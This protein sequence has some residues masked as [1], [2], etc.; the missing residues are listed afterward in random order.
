MKKLVNIIRFSGTVECVTGLAIKG[1]GNDLGIGGADSEVIRNP[2]T[3]EPYLPGSS[4]K[5]R[6]RSQLERKYGTRDKY[7]GPDQRGLPCQ[8]GRADCKICTVFGAHFNPGAASAPTRIIVRDAC[9]TD[10]FRSQ[11]Q[12]LPTE[13][14]SY[15]ELKGENIINRKTGTAE[16]PRF[17]ERVPAGATFDFEILLQILEGDDENQLRSFVEEGLHLVE[18][19]YLGGSGSRGYGKVKFHYTVDMDFRSEPAEAGL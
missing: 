16:H 7:N 9:M 17:M 3:N 15:L 8:C 12:D 6:M 11:I 5:G 13:R 18:A 19:S 2:L 10:E 14:G 1:A 4:L